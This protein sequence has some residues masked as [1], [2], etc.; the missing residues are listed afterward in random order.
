MELTEAQYAN[1]IIDETMDDF[2][3]KLTKMIERRK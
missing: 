3:Y 2:F 1:K